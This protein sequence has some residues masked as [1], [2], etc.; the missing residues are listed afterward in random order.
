MLN[1]QQ[2]SI[3]FEIAGADYF[4]H[5][6]T[7][8]TPL[9]N[10]D[11]KLDRRVRRT[12]RQLCE[13][14]LALLVERDYESITVQEI[15]TRA[16]LNRATFYHHFNHKDELLA[17]ALEDRFDELVAS[18][19]ELPVGSAMLDDRTPELLTFR[20]IAEH[21]ELYKV[22][23]GD[24]G[25]GH[26]IYRIIN[27]IARF[28]EHKLL[29]THSPHITTTIPQPIMAHHVAGSVF[30]LISWWVANDLPY[31]PEEM[32]EMAHSL[33]THGLMAALAP[34]S[35]HQAT[36]KNGAEPQRA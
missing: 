5:M 24:R 15:T 26:V 13:A 17:A 25:M 4:S 19:G 32:A 12:R 29:A 6:N 9:A 10:P 22:L 23:L 30:A 8:M 34:E 11:E 28:T 3:F 33:C 35:H 36:H 1:K 2:M 14:M 27:Y 18:F 31:T 21:A 20:H 7:R 16:D